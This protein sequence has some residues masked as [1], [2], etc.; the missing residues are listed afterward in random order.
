MARKLGAIVIIRAEVRGY[1][2]KS[3]WGLGSELPTG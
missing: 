1:A 2:F 3:I